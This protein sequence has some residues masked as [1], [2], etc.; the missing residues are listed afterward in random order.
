LKTGRAALTAQI[1][2]ANDIVGVVGSYLTLH[3]M[4]KGFKCLCPFHNDSRPSLQIN[5]EWQYFRCWSCGKRGDVFTFIQEI[6]KVSFPEAIEILAR[7]ANISL[8]SDRPQDDSKVRLLDMMKWAAEQYQRCLLETEIA[9][10]ARRYLGER[11]LS[12]PIV[13]QF[14]LGYA[15][16]SGD[17][18]VELARKGGENWEIL[19][20]IGLIGERNESN[21]FYDRFRDRVMFPIRDVKGQTIGF[22]GRILPSSPLAARAQKYYNSQQTPLFSKSDII[23]GLDLARTSGAKEGYLAVVEGYTDVMMAHQYGITHVVA[24]MGT[25]LNTRHIHQLRRIV[26]KVVLVFDGDAAGRSAVD[27]ALEI[28]ISQEVD[29]AIATLPEGLD[30]CDFLV[31]SGAEPFKQAL[32]NALDAVDFKLNQLLAQEASQGIEGT[33][34]TVDAILGILA[35][36]P[37][38]AGTSG[39]MKRSLTINRIAKRLGLREETVWTRFGE[40][41]A[42]KKES[43]RSRST[44]TSAPGE[45]ST[46]PKSGPAPP[47]ERQLLEI[48]LAESALVSKA[49]EEISLEEITHP[50]LNKLLSGLYQLR[51]QG[52][53]PDLDGLRILVNH[54]TLIHKAMEMQ[55][56]GR[57]TPD[58]RQWLERILDGFRQKRTEQSKKQVRDQLSAVTDPEAAIEILRRHTR[59]A[60]TLPNGQV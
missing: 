29:L 16:L 25:A 52:E 17:W 27:R 22:G 15:P 6:E 11:K 36:A 32:K 12:G 21:G 44:S 10:E 30:P 35:L 18:L 57:T 33:R 14:G 8:E 23:Y 56:V 19:V 37:E 41:K 3:P 1:K 55:E 7:R 38:L 20:E 13:R 53:P 48:L 58:R 46:T 31:Q 26:P 5:P 24:T 60:V 51:A 9:S 42:G 2:E 45:I 43:S 34:R 50:G 49:A 54:P 4:G 47:L 39:S 59:A 40:L 28:F